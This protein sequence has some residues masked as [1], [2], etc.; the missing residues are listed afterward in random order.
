MEDRGTHAEGGPA[1][2]Q[3]TTGGTLPE[4]ASITEMVHAM[5]DDRERWERDRRRPRMPWPRDC[6]GMQTLG[7]PKGG[8]WALNRWNEQTDGVTATDVRGAISRCSLSPRTEYCWDSK[9]DAVDTQ[10]WHRVLPYQFERVM[11]AN[12]VNGECWSYQL[13]PYRTRKAQGYHVVR[14]HAG[15]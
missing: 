14:T 2:S 3:R 6:G 5:L 7:C 4:L 8:E 13:G 11:A 9:T 15:W 1:E 10:R 12:E